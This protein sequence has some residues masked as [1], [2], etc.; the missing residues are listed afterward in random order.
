MEAVVVMGVSLLFFAV[1]LYL[2]A[3]F[4]GRAVMTASAYEQAFTG[5][6]Q[7]AYGLFGFEELEKEYSFCKDENVVSYSGVCSSVW[8][9]FSQDIRVTASVEK[10]FP[11]E[12]LRNWS[13]RDS[14]GTSAQ[15]NREQRN[16]E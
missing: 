15:Q 6:V 9:G 10:L 2:C 1:L 16:G 4:Y 13:I 11:T 14:F 5:R 8:G 7:E 12:F 3:F